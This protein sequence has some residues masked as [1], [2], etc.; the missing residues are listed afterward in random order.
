MSAQHRR[1]AE[2]LT[3]PVSAGAVAAVT[4]FASSFVLVLAG[5]AA[6]GAGPEQAA[7]GLFALCLAQFAVASLLSWRTRLPLSFVWSTPGAA[8]LVAAQGRTGSIAAAVGAFL[9]CALLVVVTGAW[10]ALARLVRRVPT[11]VAGALLAGVLLPLCLAPVSAVRV[12]PV[13][14]VCVTL[15]WLVLRRLARAAAI[16]AAMVVALG[17][18]VAGLPAAVSLEWVP[19]LLPVTPQLDPFVLV[20]LGVPLYVV[21]MAGQN[22]PGFT[23]LETLGYDRVPTGRVLVGAGVGSGLAAVFGGH[24]VNLSALAAGIIAGPGAGRDPSRRWIAAV[25]GGAGYLV[26][27]LL[28][29]PIAGLVGGTD[30][31]LVEA[32]AGLAL[33]DSFVGGLVSALAEPAHR[34]TAGLTF[35]VVASGVAFAGIGSAFW[36]LV[37]GLVVHA[38]LSRPVT[39]VTGGS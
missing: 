9:L 35:A 8:L 39:S 22:I 29:A 25:A 26:L 19:R 7:S 20:S 28:A 30:P 5:F 15:V 27:G 4:G 14:A 31:V 18:T 1:R 11:P 24:A 23:I 12:H 6:V 32:V 17:F 10:P 38:W 34:V 21:T 2:G 33:L 37:A 16:P 13:A 36:G 3:Q